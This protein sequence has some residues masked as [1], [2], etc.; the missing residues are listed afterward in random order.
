M[1]EYLNQIGITPIQFN[2]SNLNVNAPPNAR[3]YP[4]NNVRLASNALRLNNILTFLL[5]KNFFQ[6]KL[7]YSNPR[8]TT[9]KH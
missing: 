7:K 3:I 5:L 4:N 8:T 9:A 6:V 2:D 1:T